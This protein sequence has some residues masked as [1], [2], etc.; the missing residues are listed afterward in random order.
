MTCG[1][2]LPMG[3]TVEVSG[4]AIVPITGTI[5]IKGLTPSLSAVGAINH[6]GV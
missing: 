4:K 2:G 3:L 6:T 5:L 1:L